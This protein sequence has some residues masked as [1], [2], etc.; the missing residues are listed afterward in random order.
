MGH[1]LLPGGDVAALVAGREERGGRRGAA[2]GRTVP[3]V[4]LRQG[5]RQTPAPA[6][7]AAALRNAQAKTLF[8]RHSGR[9][10]D[11]ARSVRRGGP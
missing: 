2:Q 3:G 4:F 5:A 9:R 7:C 8:G 10:E 6:A 11:D 1:R